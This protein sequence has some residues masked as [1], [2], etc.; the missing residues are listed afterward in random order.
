MFG[1][2]VMTLS[3]NAELKPNAPD[4]LP[5]KA[6]LLDLAQLLCEMAIAQPRIA[7]LHEVSH[8]SDQIW[9]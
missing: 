4:R 2:T 5:T 9:R 3:R 8:L 6:Q 1:S 7:S